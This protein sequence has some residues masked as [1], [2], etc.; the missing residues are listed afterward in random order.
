MAGCFRYEGLQRRVG[1]GI[2][3]GPNGRD[4]LEVLLEHALREVRIGL[5]EVDPLDDR[6]REG[7]GE[8]LLRRS[9][10]VYAR[11]PL[12]FEDPRIRGIL[13]R[14]LRHARL[15]PLD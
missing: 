11:R 7:L 10:E 1:R 15:P 13:P 12:R 3:V 6:L 8:R 14:S 4:S 5:R 2:E 9:F